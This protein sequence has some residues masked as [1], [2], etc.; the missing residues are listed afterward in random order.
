MLLVLGSSKGGRAQ[1]IKN[2]KCRQRGKSGRSGEADEALGI[3]IPLQCLE[4]T[5]KASK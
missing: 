2:D 4:A 1:K 5:L 3:S